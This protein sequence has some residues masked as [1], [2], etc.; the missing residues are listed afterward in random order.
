MTPE[1]QNTLELAYAY[2]RDRYQRGR[3]A[4]AAR[5]QRNAAI[6]RDWAVVDALNATEPPV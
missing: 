4:E 3:F 6:Y 5:E 2:A 1:Q